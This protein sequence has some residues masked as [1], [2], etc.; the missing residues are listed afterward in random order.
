MRA[1]PSTTYSTSAPG[2]LCMAMRLAGPM[3][4]CV[5]AAFCARIVDSSTSSLTENGGDAAGAPFFLPGGAGGP[6]SG[7]S[8]ALI[9][10]CAVWPSNDSG[11]TT[12]LP[13][14]MPASVQV[15]ALSTRQ[16]SNT[17]DLTPSLSGLALVTRPPSPTS[18]ASSIFPGDV[19]GVGQRLLEAAVDLAAVFDQGGLQ[20]VGDAR[21]LRLAR[22]CAR[23][24]RAARSASR[25]DGQR[26]ANRPR[27]AATP[28]TRGRRSR[29][30]HSTICLRRRAGGEDG[31][32]AHRLQRRRVVIGDDA[33][34]EQNDVTCA[35]R[36]AA[37]RARPGK[38]V[39]CAPDIID[40]PTASTD[41]CCAAAAII[42]GVW[43]RPL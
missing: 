22:A 43:W 28:S 26:C 42:S 37:R 40:S 33:A 1:C 16:A 3:V 24:R 12:V 11:T 9:E 15:A 7:A 27:H 41:S 10:N 34:A 21:L 20:D 8:L 36:G 4:S 25:R 17:G 39:M 30:I 13:G 14:S 29:S 5:S 19:Q 32:D 35:A 38:W 6:R 23:A 2:C 18:T 31:G